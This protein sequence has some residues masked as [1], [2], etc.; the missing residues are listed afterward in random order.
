MVVLIAISCSVKVKVVK[1]GRT[2]LFSKQEIL[3]TIAKYGGENYTV[4]FPDTFLYIRLYSTPLVMALDSVGNGLN[5]SICYA[6]F[7][8]G[9][10]R[11]LGDIET[12]DTSYVATKKYKGYFEHLRLED[13]TPFTFLPKNKYTVFLGVGSPNFED[14]DYGYFM[15]SLQMSNLENTDIYY[16]VQIN[17]KELNFDK[18]VANKRRLNFMLDSGF[19]LPKSYRKQAGR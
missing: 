8:N 17:Y 12:L 14:G 18:E 5:T 15:K 1:G 10:K 2:E 6:N 4:V 19:D 11:V 7:R 16:I 9:H 3:D 13:E